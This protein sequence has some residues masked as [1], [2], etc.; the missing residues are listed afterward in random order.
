MTLRKSWLVAGTTPAD[1]ATA[2]DGRL[3][4]AG[5][6]ARDASGLV[7]AGILGNRSGVV[8]ARSDMALDI[9][10]FEAVLTRG[11][12]YGVTPIANDGTLT[13]ELPPAPSSNSRFVRVYVLQRD[14][15]DGADADNEPILAAVA[16][17]AAATPAWPAL[18]TG[19]LPIA[20]VLQ[21]ANVLGTVDCTVVE[22]FPMT[23]A[24]G[25]IVPTRDLAERDAWAPAPGE[26]SY[27]LAN[28]RTYTRRGAGWVDLDPQ[29][30]TVSQNSDE[31]GYLL[32]NHNLGVVPDWVQVTRSLYGSD[33]IDTIADLIVVSKSPTQVRLRYIRR[34]TNY[35]FPNNPVRAWVTVGVN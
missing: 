23:T 22:E 5:L 35:W 13:I 17:A 16:G 29:G 34:D 19:A 8:S 24:I 28:G 12:L 26:K 6:Y 32:V 14:N 9:G 20:R 11:A 27:L 1:G 3:A 33:S 30:V 21:P 25:G 15:V 2:L 31:N 18:P 7:R 10:P 4:Q